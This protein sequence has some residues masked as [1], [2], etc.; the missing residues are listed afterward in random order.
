MRITLD[1][2]YPYCLFLY[3]WMEN[4]QKRNASSRDESMKVDLG[5]ADLVILAPKY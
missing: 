1:R 2:N 4:Q 3:V 5:N